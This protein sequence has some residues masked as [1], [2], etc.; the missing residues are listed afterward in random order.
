MPSQRR[1]SSADGCCICGV[2]NSTEPFVTV[3]KISP[4]QKSVTEVLLKCFQL[5]KERTGEICES[6]TSIAKKWLKTSKSKRNTTNFKKVVDS[7]RRFKQ[8][9]TRRSSQSTDYNQEGSSKRSKNDEPIPKAKLPSEEKS[10]T[11][12][13][14][15]Y[16]QAPTEDQLSEEEQEALPDQIDNNGSPPLAFD[17]NCL[18]PD[19]PNEDRTEMA[20]KETVSVGTQTAFLFPALTSPQANANRLPFIDLSKWRQEEI[21]CGTIFRGPNGEVLVDP[22][23]LRPSCEMCNRSSQPPTPVEKGNSEEISVFDDKLASLCS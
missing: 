21:C 1:Y 15:E 12:S 17:S 13:I 6:C 7:K 14:K 10:E 5:E 8:R 9:T 2:N 23:W 18:S 11:E 20:E 16:I 22:K 19:I 3:D 4:N